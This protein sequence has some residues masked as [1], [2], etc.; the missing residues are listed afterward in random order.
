MANVSVFSVSG[1]GYDT[2]TTAEIAAAAATQTVPCG[3]DSRLALRVDN[4][5]ETA[6]A[7]V[8]VAAGSGPRAP[9][10]NMD[11]MVEAGKTAYIA[12]FD[13]ARYKTGGAIT[14]ALVDAEGVPLGAAALED[15]RIEAV[16]L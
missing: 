11:I 14:V 9:L 6:A 15:I 7:V 13:T 3:K 1:G 10:G 4:G 5:N 2:A 8:S 12:L 16:Q